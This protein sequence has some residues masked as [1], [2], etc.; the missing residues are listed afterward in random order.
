MPVNNFE[1]LGKNIAGPVKNLADAKLLYQLFYFFRIRLGKILPHNV[2]HAADRKSIKNPF[3]T[4][5]VGM[6]EK[7]F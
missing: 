5:R 4:E 1:S 7:S 6:Q 3:I 2:F